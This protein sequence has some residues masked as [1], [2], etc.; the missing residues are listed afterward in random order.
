M[1]AED[2]AGINPSKATV[3]APTAITFF[4]EPPLPILPMVFGDSTLGVSRIHVTMASGTETRTEAG[5]RS[6]GRP[7]RRTARTCRPRR[8]GY[9]H[10][11]DAG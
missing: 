5:L 9:G 8:E 2:G 7:Q 10:S 11:G 1:C 3:T 4:M 6:L